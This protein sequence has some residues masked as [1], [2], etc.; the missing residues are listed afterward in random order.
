MI[1][2]F[3]D[4]IVYR[5]HTHTKSRYSEHCAFVSVIFIYVVV[6]VSVFLQMP[7]QCHGIS[8]VER[9]YYKMF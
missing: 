9:L 3:P 6:K 2:V 8:F 4:V 5:M 1:S 7:L